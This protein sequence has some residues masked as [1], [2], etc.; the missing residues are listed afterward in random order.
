MACG[1]NLPPDLQEAVELGLLT[2]AEAWT[3]ADDRLLNAETPYP[4]EMYPLLRRLQ[5]L[6]W[7]P[8]EMTR[9]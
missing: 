8:S 6:D 5:M 1:I 3:L 7:E 9:Q 2:I 4:H